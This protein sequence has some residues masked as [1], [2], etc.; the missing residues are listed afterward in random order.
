MDVKDKVDRIELEARLHATETRLLEHQK[1]LTLILTVLGK[2]MQ[3]KEPDWNHGLRQ[4][5]LLV[6]E[7]DATLCGREGPIA[8]FR[9]LHGNT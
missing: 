3:E 2:T 8:K 6:D 1:C 4:V 5:N 9:R 7:M